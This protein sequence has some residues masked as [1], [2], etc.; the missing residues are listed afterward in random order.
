MERQGNKSII[1]SDQESDE[2]KS[3]NAYIDKTKWN[4]F[5]IGVPVLFNFYHGLE[6]FMKGLLQELNPDVRVTNHK[7]T[8]LEL[9]LKSAIPEIPESLLNI[10]NIH[11]SSR[12]PFHNFFQTNKLGVDKFYELLKYPE[13]LGGQ[14]FYFSDIRGNEQLGLS[15]FRKIRKSIIDLKKEIIEWKRNKSGT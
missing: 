8:E 7:L 14:E 1:F 12:S 15:K 10:L 4:D 3:W 6:L 5:N 2:E 11:L 9:K 13:S